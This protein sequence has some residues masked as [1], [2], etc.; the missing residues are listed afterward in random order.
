MMKSL[1]W[2][3]ETEF[4]I[5]GVNFQCA[6]GNY[7]Q[8]TTPGKIAILKDRPSLSQYASVFA[9][10][11]PKNILEFGIFQGGSPTLFSLWFG[12]EKFVGI[13]ICQPV[14]GFEEFCQSHPV[15]RRIRS[16]YGV[17][18]S[19]E[20]KVKEIVEAE[21]GAT[22]IDA[23]IDDASHQYERSRRTFEI[24]FPLLRPG[25]TYV[26]EDWGWAHWPDF[27]DQ[28]YAEKTPLSMLVMELTMACASRGDLISEVR[29]FP[30]FAFIRKAAHA[31]PMSELSLDGLYFKRNLELVGAQH[32]N[33]KAVSHL[34]ATRLVNRSRRGIERAGGKLSRALGVRK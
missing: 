11:V 18:Q 15:G 12:T 22:P 10:E 21:F 26:I 23:I 25:G 6:L 33:L 34:V 13:D 31:Q 16:Y 2:N 19:D 1:N 4:E 28:S 5:E 20:P 32:L 30:S 27:K 29:I 17:S 3:S 7:S 9:E 24:T 14:Q 8:K